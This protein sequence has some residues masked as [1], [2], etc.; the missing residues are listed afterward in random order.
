V[1][2][3]LAGFALAALVLVAD[4]ASKYWV[5]H[6]LHLQDGHFL[7][8]LPVLNFVLVWNRGVTFGLFNGP[9]AFNWI[10]LALLALAVVTALGS[11]LWRTDNLFKMLAIGAIMGGAVGNVIDRL[12]FGAVVDFIQAH[13][14]AY[15][16]YVFNVGDSAIVCGV[17]ALMAESLLRRDPGGDRKAA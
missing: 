1:N 12:R 7:V 11:W 8:L 3:R 16:F 6:G 9:G 5:L 4:Q 2:H 17:I 13:L 10:I 14:G 15:S